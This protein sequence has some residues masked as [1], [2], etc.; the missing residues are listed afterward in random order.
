MNQYVPYTFFEPQYTRP[1]FESYSSRNHEQRRLEEM[2]RLKAARLSIG[3]KEEEAKPFVFDPQPE[4]A[5]SNLEFVVKVNV[6]GKGP[7]E[8]HVH[9][10]EEAYE[11]AADFSQKHHITDKSKQHALLQM[12]QR[13]I[14]DHRHPRVEPEQDSVANIEV[15][16]KSNLNIR[17]P[18]DPKI[19]K[20]LEVA[21]N[22]IWY[23]YN[24]RSGTVKF[25]KYMQVMKQL[26]Q[27]RKI[28]D[29]A[30]GPFSE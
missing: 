24:P 16:P 10:D 28:K 25:D 30:S 11:L 17:K 8:I 23:D 6:A 20:E 15:A 4:E 2:R 27:Y 5:S 1:A 3:K 7:R 13:K 9:E 18:L 21:F 26:K 12:L 22:D 29:A 19:K 14:Q